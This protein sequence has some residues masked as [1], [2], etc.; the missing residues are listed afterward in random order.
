MLLDQYGAFTK[1]MLLPYTSLRLMLGLSFSKQ[2]SSII[3]DINDFE[4]LKKVNN[5][6]PEFIFH[7]AAQP[8]VYKI[9]LRQKYI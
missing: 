1:G 4:R 7:L 5:F 8:L 6:Q 3:S 2:H 9:I